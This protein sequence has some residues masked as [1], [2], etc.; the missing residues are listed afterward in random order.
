MKQMFA[1][2]H[3]SEFPPRAGV[4]LLGV[5]NRTYLQTDGNPV[6]V[7]DY[8]FKA[9][10]NGQFELTVTVRGVLSEFDLSASLEELKQQD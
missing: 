1:K 2:I 9:S 8:S 3:E 4:M 7:K 5:G 6:E 10:E